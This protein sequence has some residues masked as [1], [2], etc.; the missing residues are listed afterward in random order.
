MLYSPESLVFCDCSSFVARF[1]TVIL[2]PGMPLPE[3]S[4][5]RPLKVARNSWALRPRPKRQARPRNVIDCRTDTVAFSLIYASSETNRHQ[6]YHFYI[7]RSIDE[8]AIFDYICIGLSLDDRCIIDA[9]PNS[10]RLF[11]KRFSRKRNYVIRRFASRS[12]RTSKMESTPPGRA[13]L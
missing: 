10:S 1:L 13:C 8:F 6:V 7:Y 9:C 5:I 2:A 3:G 4:V 12:A 11:P